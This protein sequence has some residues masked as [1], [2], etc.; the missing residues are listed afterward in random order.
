MNS[1]GDL[2]IP[3]EKTTI[4]G[5]GIDWWGDGFEV[6]M[7]GGHL[8][9]NYRF[10]WL[11]DQK[12]DNFLFVMVWCV[13]MMMPEWGWFNPLSHIIVILFLFHA[14]MVWESHTS[15]DSQVYIVS[16]VCIVFGQNICLRALTFS[17]DD[18]GRDTTRHKLSKLHPPTHLP[19]QCV[20]W[21]NQFCGNRLS[22]ETNY[23]F[24]F[25]ACVH[26]YKQ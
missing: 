10:E 20:I 13:M 9:I 25:Y 26:S 12:K 18:T 16:C 24:L 4:T 11:S 17:T 8:I 5:D 21:I 14:C 22:L 1:L 23:L 7:V 3:E 6:R 2:G 19:N 15:Q